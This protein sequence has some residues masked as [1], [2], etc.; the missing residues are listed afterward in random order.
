MGEVVEGYTSTLADNLW[1]KTSLGL[2]VLQIVVRLRQLFP[3]SIQLTENTH[4]HLL[5]SLVGKGYCQ[6]IAIALRILYQQAD[7]FGGQGE[8]LTTSS[9]GFIYGE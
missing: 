8:S 3:D 1:L 9:T 5:G 4:L 2:D 6:D 7:I